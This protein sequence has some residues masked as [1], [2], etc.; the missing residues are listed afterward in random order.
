MRVAGVC[1]VATAASAALACAGDSTAADA[2]PCLLTTD[3]PSLSVALGQT[4]QVRATSSC[5]RLGAA[6][7]RWTSSA[8]DVV[9]VDS[10]TGV[11][12]AL[13]TGDA[14]LHATIPGERSAAIDVRVSVS[15]PAL[16]EIGPT[17]TPAT[18][19]L[20]TGGVGR[21][22]ASMR[23][24]LGA[25]TCTVV[26]DTAF[27]FASLDT[28]IAVVDATGLVTGR[29]PGQAVVRASLAA[30]PTVAASLPV[31]VTSALAPLAGISISPTRLA[32]PTW[33][34]QPLTAVVSLA[35]GA[36]AGTSTAVVFRSSNACVARVTAGDTLTAGV[37]GTATIT[38]LAV[39]DTNVQ[40]DVQVV[41]G[42]TRGPLRFTLQSITSGTP[43][44]PADIGALRGRVA[45]TVNVDPSALSGGARFELALAGRIVA[46]TPV[47]P[48]RGTFEPV[49]VTT[50]VDTD[51][52][53]AAGARLYPNGPQKLVATLGYGAP[54]SPFP[55]CDTSSPGINQQATI[56]LQ[57]TLANP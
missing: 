25:P 17:L 51:A 22:R 57:V 27:T 44:T 43:P 12:T 35:A 45:V 9:A 3:T 11:A 18:L 4:A 26:T 28:T 50:T 46:T 16:P 34:T 21:V 24:S 10:L 49:P 55:E 52:R 19:T 42:P 13:R 8:P 5:A 39:A 38:A 31:T 1:L 14:T 30:S 6:L 53:D 48:V 56:Q 41:V 36:P 20:A 7:V 23:R 40:A 15:C 32:L 37:A 54:V 47:S 33:G 29:R 2:T